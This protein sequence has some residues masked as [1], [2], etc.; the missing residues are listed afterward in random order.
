MMK[1][2]TMV[3]KWLSSASMIGLLIVSMV[4]SQP[5]RHAEAMHA[6]QRV[7]ATPVPY[8]TMTP[9]PTSTPTLT[10]TL[11]PEPVQ[12]DRIYLPLMIR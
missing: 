12:V 3:Q 2:M 4:C 11:V 1:N 5:Q 8:A 6:Y 7:T 9:M 10:P